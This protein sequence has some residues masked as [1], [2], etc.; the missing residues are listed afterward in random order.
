MIVQRNA[1]YSVSDYI[2]GG[3]DDSGEEFSALAVHAKAAA[4]YD[5]AVY[6]GSQ[7]RADA[8]DVAARVA[9]LDALIQRTIRRS[10]QGCTVIT[11]ARE[12]SIGPPRELGTMLIVW[13]GGPMRSYP[14]HHG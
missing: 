12:F 4:L 2:R 9:A 1:N 3:V 7:Y 5:R 10:F 14:D 8:P 11:I 6:I 13:G